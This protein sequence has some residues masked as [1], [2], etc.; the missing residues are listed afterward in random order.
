MKPTLFRRVFLLLL[1]CLLAA[2]FVPAFASAAD[3]SGGKLYILTP[4]VPRAAYYLIDEVRQFYASLGESSL[5]LYSSSSAFAWDG[6]LNGTRIT[7]DGG[8]WIENASGPEAYGLTYRSKGIATTTGQPFS[9]YDKNGKPSGGYLY[10]QKVVNSA[11]VTLGCG[12]GYAREYAGKYG[13]SISCNQILPSRM[14]QNDGEWINR[15]ALHP[16]VSKENPLVLYDT[17]IG[18]GAVTLDGTAAFCL[19]KYEGGY[20]G[21]EVC[22]RVQELHAKRAKKVLSTEEVV[23]ANAPI[24]PEMLCYW[25]GWTFSPLTKAGNDHV[26]RML[27]EQGYEGFGTFSFQK[28]VSP[29]GSETL[30]YGTQERRTDLGAYQFEAVVRTDCTNV[31]A[32]IP[33]SG[34]FIWLFSK[35]DTPETAD[36]WARY[37]LSSLILTE[38]MNALLPPDIDAA[39]PAGTA[40]APRNPF[41]SGTCTD[42]VFEE[43]PEWKKADCATLYRHIW[44]SPPEAHQYISNWMGSLYVYTI[45]YMPEGV[46]PQDAEIALFVKLHPLGNSPDTITLRAKKGE[47]FSALMDRLREQLQ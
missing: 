16:A 26:N 11:V 24:A 43:A 38:R 41:F 46:S 25:T 9:F 18:L 36:T 5:E 30:Y 4:K 47:T 22:L 17:D 2:L 37:Q 3:S 19:Q 6:D 40:S 31:Y 1:V 39:L 21:Q 32:V 12:L 42:A 44:L 8:Y 13:P 14:E 29:T 27:E 23:C 34:S 45:A 10:A 15:L 33:Q 28:A 35:K 20:S 7:T